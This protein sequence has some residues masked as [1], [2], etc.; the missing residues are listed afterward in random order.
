MPK[1]YLCHANSLIEQITEGV[2]PKG[3]L[4]PSE[5]EIC[6]K[7]N[8]SR[9]TARQAL[10]I[11]AQ[12]GYITSIQG[13]GTVV[14]HPQIQQELGTIYSFDEDMRQLGKNPETHIMDFIEMSAPDALAAIFSLPPGCPIYRIMRLRLAD[15]KPMLLETNFL[16]CS[17]F[18]HLDHKMLE[19]QSLYRILKTQFNLVITMAEETFEPVS[20]RPM[21]SQILGTPANA[22]GMLVERISYENDKVVEFSKSVSPSYKFKH[23][24]VLNR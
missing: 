17:R 18:P 24:V 3:C 5:R 2:Y 20:L 15:Q 10:N 11:L 1:K 8:I 19:N 12:E 7:Y 21:E 14:T 6:E 23:H 4:L 13:K 9:T 16:P 22:L